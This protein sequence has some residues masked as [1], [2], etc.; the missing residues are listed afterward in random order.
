MIAKAQYEDKKYAGFYNVGPDEKDCVTTGD[1]VDIFCSKW[2]QVS[3]GKTV[4]MATLTKQTSLNL[5]VPF[6][7]PP[8]AGSQSGVSKKQSERLLSGPNTG[9]TA[10]V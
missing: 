7:N 9:S 3:P 5:T 4:T 1:L 10:R 6:S 8:S 2:G